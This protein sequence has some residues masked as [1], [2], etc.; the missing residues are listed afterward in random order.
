MHQCKNYQHSG[1]RIH[2]TN[3]AKSHKLIIHDVQIVYIIFHYILF[4]LK[5]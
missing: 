1:K 5:P 2:K 3:N 4:L